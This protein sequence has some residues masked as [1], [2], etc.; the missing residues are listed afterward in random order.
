M[1]DRV[2]SF[3]WGVFIFFVGISPLSAQLDMQVQVQDYEEDTLYLGYYFGD[4]KYFVPSRCDL[5]VTP[6]F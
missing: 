5:K 3:I 2:L 4:K 6:S 1:Q